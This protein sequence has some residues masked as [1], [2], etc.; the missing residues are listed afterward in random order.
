MIYGKVNLTT[1]N[2]LIELNEKYYNKEK[3]D[4]LIN[5]YKTEE[6]IKEKNPRIH[7]IVTGRAMKLVKLVMSRNGKKEE[8]DRSL[9]YLQT[10]IDAKKY[11]LDVKKCF[12]EMNV[13]ELLDKYGMEINHG[14][15]K[16]E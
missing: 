1:A 11:N 7:A 2:V 4:E 13:K 9:E 3:R 14:G 12:N 6:D 8:I 15:I 16:R 5:K 10:C